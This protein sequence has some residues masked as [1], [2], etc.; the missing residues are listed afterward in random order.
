MNHPLP[1]LSLTDFEE[2]VR[3]LLLAPEPPRA[4]PGDPLANDELADAAGAFRK[5]ALPSL[6]LTE[7]QVALYRRLVRGNLSRAILMAIPVARARLGDAFFEARIAA[8]LAEAPPRT[9]VLRE[10]P[11]AFAGWMATQADESWPAA[12]PEL[13]HFECVEI[14]V[15][16]APDATP[17]PGLPRQPH[18]DGTLLAH[19]SARLLAYRHAVHQLRADASAWPEATSAPLF[20]IAF[21]VDEAMRVLEIPAVVARVL[22]LCDAEASLGPA[23][24]ALEAESGSCFRRED[25]LEWLRHLA[26]AGA[27]LGFPTRST[28]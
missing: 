10:V 22:L 24:A 27:L 13:L 15:N 12:L 17:P 5:R 6:G 19:P 1:A 3:A 20:L 16:H 25:V 8:F 18:L 9:R 21:R 2:R 26:A 14:E 4:N 11:A 23:F 7:A 28:P